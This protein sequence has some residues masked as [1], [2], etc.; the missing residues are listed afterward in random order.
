MV[1]EAKEGVNL[2]MERPSSGIFGA[3]QIHARDSPRL[4]DPSKHEER[5]R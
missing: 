1:R 2:Y 3:I 5:T 4:S